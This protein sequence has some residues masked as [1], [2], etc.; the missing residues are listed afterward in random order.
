MHKV[1]KK[2]AVI[3]WRYVILTLPAAS[4]WLLELEIHDAS[5]MAAQ[6]RAGGFF[7]KATRVMRKSFSIAHAT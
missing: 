5:C 1:S 2:P 4:K 7:V 3:R 6:A